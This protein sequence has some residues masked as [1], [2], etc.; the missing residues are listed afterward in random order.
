VLREQAKSSPTGSAAIYAQARGQI[1]R[2]LALVE[3]GP[4]ED[5]LLVKVREVKAE[6][7]EEEQDYRLVQALDE[8]RL[9]QAESAE[10]ENRFAQERAIPL[11]REA[12]AGYG[13]APGEVDVQAAA[14]RIMSRP[15]A[16][17]NV[18]LAVLDE[19][20]TLVDEPELKITEPHRQWLEDVL[21]AAEPA[22]G[23]LRQFRTAKQEADE[24]VR[25]ERLRELAKSID[26]RSLPAAALSRL[27]Q[28]MEPAAALELLRRVQ[29]RYPQD[30]WINQALGKF[31][32]ELNPPETAEA[33]R[34]LTAAVALRPASA[35]AHLNLG[36][37]L[38]DQGHID[39]A[40][41]SYRR[42]VEIEPQS[43]GAYG[44]LGITLQSQGQID[45]AI[46]SYRKAIEIAP[47]YAAAH[48]NLGN[49]MRD[50]S[51]LDEAIASYRKAIEIDPQLSAAYDNL[52]N[53]L[54]DQGQFDEAIA[55]HRK[56]I[57]IDPKNAVIH[58]NLGASLSDQGQF[59]EAIASHRKA[60]E[61]DP[62]YA[63]AH[64]NLG[65]ALKSQGHLHE[66]IAS[67]RKAIE[68]DPKY[69]V[70][71]SNLGKAQHNLGR[72]DEAIAS[73]RKAIEL[74]PEDVAAHS[75][76]GAE[77]I[78]LG[79]L[80]EAIASCQRAIEI[81][82]KFVR[83]YV[84]LGFASAEKG[85]LDEAITAYRKALEI[86]PEFATAHGSLGLALQSQGHLDEAIEHFRKAVNLEPSNQSFI[87]SLNQ[88]EQMMELHGK[89][90][91]LMEGRHIPPD[92]A[93]RLALAQL[94]Q[95][96]RLHSL[97]LQLY[98]EAFAADPVTADD[99][100]ASHR[101]NA[102]CHAALA[103]A[104]DGENA[105]ELTDAERASLRQQALAWLRADLALRAEQL[106]TGDDSGKDK[107]KRMLEHWQ[108]DSDLSSIRD[109]QALAQLP[110]EE[111]TAFEEL[112]AKVGQLLESAKQ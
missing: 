73:F 108:N 53:A 75:N 111:R 5:Q 19:W 87:Y 44:N 29:Q 36:V 106:S 92:N 6:L 83:S 62:K 7:D 82:P 63:F 61:I 38:R 81:D 31:L 22:D 45:E 74:D 105:G 54:A 56:A 70:A 13:L 3:S 57:E 49:A 23:W 89:L 93:E 35:G 69:A 24:A 16:V 107:S 67:Y 48:L 47:R 101:Y 99:L 32:Q 11:F 77:L 21:E 25:K 68:I 52:G 112:W 39:E 37:A 65:N 30:F 34:F 46:A 17:Q 88:L 80:D 8:A 95:H 86:N 41:A 84:A 66:A 96:R 78:M 97:A 94:C 51:H 58:S 71:Y 26:V 91:A 4:A 50:Q 43:S 79:Q 85:K 102:A 42:A 1:E 18:V 2:A 9:A 40:I 60:I 90:P 27:A 55:S 15:P 33:V 12:L 76:L 100:N 64:N 10:G 72:F 20:I 109:P 59:D 28:R 104:G 103:A 110:D 98:T 14:K